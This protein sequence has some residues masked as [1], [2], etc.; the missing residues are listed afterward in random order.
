SIDGRTNL[1]GEERLQRNDG[2]WNGRPGWR[3][4]PE[5]ASAKL[6]I[7]APSYP[8]VE[9]L[10]C[11]QRFQLVYEDAVAVVFLRRQDLP[12]SDP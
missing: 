8:L 3:D 12:P 1:H 10:R 2:T 11:D 7:G 4:D 6:V 9:L 5:L